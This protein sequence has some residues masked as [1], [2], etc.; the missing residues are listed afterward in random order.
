V[1]SAKL[2]IRPCEMCMLTKGCSVNEL[3]FMRACA[4]EHRLIT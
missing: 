3:G 2:N 4:K 1:N